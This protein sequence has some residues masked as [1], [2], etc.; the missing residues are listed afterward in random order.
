MGMKAPSVSSCTNSDC[1]NNSQ[2]VQVCE[3]DGH[4]SYCD[5]HVFC[6]SP[7]HGSES[8]GESEGQ[9]S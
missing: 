4:C 2:Q 8:E 9:A 6:D 5:T 7:P 1:P 3:K